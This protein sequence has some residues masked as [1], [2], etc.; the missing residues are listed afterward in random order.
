MRKFNSFEQFA[1][2][3]QAVRVVTGEPRQRIHQYK[4][5]SPQ[6]SV[7]ERIRAIKKLLGPTKKEQLFVMVFGTKT[8]IKASEVP[9]YLQSG[10]KI[11]KEVITIPRK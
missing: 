3:R 7:D 5:I 2:D 10:F 9:T 4:K 11:H 8:I 1:Q 6:D